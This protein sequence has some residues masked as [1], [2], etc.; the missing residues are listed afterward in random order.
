MSSYVKLPEGINGG[1]PSDPRPSFSGASGL[2]RKAPQQRL[3]GSAAAAP[4]QVMRRVAVLVH[5]A[6]VRAWNWSTFTKKLWKTHHF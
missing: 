3:H 4:R 2:R 6:D 1:F 5:G